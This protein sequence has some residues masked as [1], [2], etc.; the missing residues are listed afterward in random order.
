MYKLYMLYASIGVLTVR[1]DYITLYI[2]AFGLGLNSA[3]ETLKLL[4]GTL[5]GSRDKNCNDAG[6]S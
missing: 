4:W 3:L 5:Y 2:S 1:K 6:F